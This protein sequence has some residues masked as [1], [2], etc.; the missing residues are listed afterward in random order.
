MKTHLKPGL[1]S[2]W[3]ADGGRP[4]GDTGD[5]H[6]GLIQSTE[7]DERSDHRNVPSG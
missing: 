7:H 2:Q 4:Q 3:L 6:G 5:S 1:T